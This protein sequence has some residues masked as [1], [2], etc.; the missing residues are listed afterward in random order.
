MKVAIFNIYSFNRPFFEK[1]KN[2]ND[3]LVYFKNNFREKHLI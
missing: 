1:I 3:E 2:H